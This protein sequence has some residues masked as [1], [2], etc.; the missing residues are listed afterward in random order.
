MDRLLVLGALVAIVVVG[1]RA[2]APQ[3][4]RVPSRRPWFIIG[5]IA[6]L[7][8]AGLLVPWVLAKLDPPWSESPSGIFVYLGKAL[9]VGVPGLL[10]LG[11]LI[12]AVFPGRSDWAA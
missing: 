9:V 8:L 5:S 3:C 6:I 11:A 1:Y 7:C 12:G 4:R 10:A 2:S